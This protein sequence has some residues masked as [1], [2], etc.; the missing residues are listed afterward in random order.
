MTFSD[1]PLCF[2][3]AEY[4]KVTKDYPT[5]FATKDEESFTPRCFL[6]WKYKC[7]K[8]GG[9]THFNG[10]SWCPSCKEFTCVSCTEEKMVR[11]EFI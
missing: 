5:N 9:L 8:C 11:K 7:D 6:H 4:V 10:I 3:C 2:Y 1:K